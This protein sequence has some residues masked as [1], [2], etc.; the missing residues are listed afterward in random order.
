MKRFFFVIAAIL[1]AANIMA[2]EK[3]S[4]VIEGSENTYNQ[5]RLINR[6]S[7]T[8]IRCRVVVLDDADNILSVYGVYNMSGYDDADFITDRI[9]RG[10][11]IGLQFPEDFKHELLYSVEYRDYPFF[12]AVVVYLYDK[13]G[14]FNSE[15]K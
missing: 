14:E 9:R 1:M 7:L 8:D 6:T 15:F 4:F 2:E 3:F 11:K 12:D 10:T 13:N 5:V